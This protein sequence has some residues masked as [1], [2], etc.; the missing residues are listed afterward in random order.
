[1]QTASCVRIQA[2]VTGLQDFEALGWH[3]DSVSKVHEW[4]RVHELEVLNDATEVIDNIYTRLTSLQGSTN[5]AGT[6]IYTTEWHEFGAGIGGEAS[7]TEK[8]H[9]T[10]S[11]EHNLAR[12]FDMEGASS[13][14]GKLWV[15]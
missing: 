2:Y 10:T 7:N 6:K 13:F 9:A 5:D 11:I 4:R 15:A 1:M 3:K 14:L 8:R 12:E